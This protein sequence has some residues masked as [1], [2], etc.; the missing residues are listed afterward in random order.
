MAH[1]HGSSR[2]AL[3]IA[4]GIELGYLGV[5]VVGAL[6]SGSLAL[7]ADAA[8]TALDILALGLAWG[9]AW[10]ATR[11][12]TALRS[13]GFM[14]AE[15]IAALVNGAALLIVA[16]SI[17]T[18][19]AQRLGAPPEVRGGI[20]SLV[21]SG[22]LTANVIAGA[23]LLRSSRSNLN[24]RAAFLHIMGDGLG[25]IA[26]I[27]AG[28]LV[29]AFDWRFAD[30]ALSVFIALILIYVA[31]RVVRDAVH[32]LLEGTPEHVDV[33]MLRGDIAGVPNVRGCH[34]LHVWTITSGYHALSAHVTL[35]DD[36][37][38]ECARA[39]RGELSAMLRDRYDI[40]HVT[41]QLE[42]GDG[43]ECEEEAH[44]PRSAL[45][46]EGG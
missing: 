6:V 21:A 4:G 3:G 2:K 9:A 27:V 7:L 10:L 42:Q 17:I 26:A 43:D 1:G 12:D 40:S 11:P 13:F 45:G 25:S 20:V 44:M 36:C 16:V 18:E 15:V 8:H 14:R 24:V 29:L 30:P 34:D 19:A 5:E 23:L 22:G 33:D 28:V 37:S 46:D 35:P 38:V 32:V 39:V 31:V 41:L